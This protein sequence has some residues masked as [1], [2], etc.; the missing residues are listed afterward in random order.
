MAFWKKIFKSKYTGAEIDAAVAK[1]GTVPAVTSADAGKALVVDSEGKIV[2]GAAGGGS[3]IFVFY[4]SEDETTGEPVFSKTYTEIKAAIAE[5][6]V[7]VGFNDPNWD[8]NRPFAEPV[9]LLHNNPSNLFF[10]AKFFDFDETFAAN[11]NKY[12]L[13]SDNTLTVTA[14]TYTWSATSDQ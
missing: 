5:G 9:L 8:G 3:D 11:R 7:P 6:K 1:A 12:V 14:E 4:V 13:A 2:P 10:E